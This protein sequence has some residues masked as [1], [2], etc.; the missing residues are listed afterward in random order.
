MPVSYKAYCLRAAA[1]AHVIEVDQAEVAVGAGQGAGG[2]AEAG[3]AVGVADV[4]LGEDGGEEEQEQKRMGHS[5]VYYY[6]NSKGK[7]KNQ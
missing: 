6:R 3:L 5:A 7:L 1:D 4:V 2:L